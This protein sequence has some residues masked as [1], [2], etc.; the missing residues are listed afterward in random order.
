MVSSTKLFTSWT[1]LVVSIA[2]V[3]IEKRGPSVLVGYRSVSPALAQIYLKAGSTLTYDP[4]A[5]T[6]SD[7]IGAGAYISPK[8]GDWPTSDEYWDCAVLAESSAWN[9][10]EKAWI[11]E[12]ADNGCTPLWWDKGASNRKAY[13]KDLGGA[14][15]TPDNT[16]VMSIAEGF[17]K[18]QLL[19]PPGLMGAKA[20][21]NL[22]VQCAAKKDTDA[23][24][25]ISLYGEA[26][27][28]SL[29]NVK[30]TPLHL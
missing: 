17:N 18:L 13:L 20:G 23:I 11:P 22:K 10:V 5:S 21:L 7:Q 24:K 14:I 27:W 12:Y 26:D 8:I 29:N 4:K 9:L 6:S 3:A 30:G 19:I 28:Y 1:L 2:A 16:V 25:R 15:M